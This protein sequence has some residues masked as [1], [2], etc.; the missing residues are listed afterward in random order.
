MVEVS[1]PLDIEPTDLVAAQTAGRP[2]VLVDCREQWEYEIVHLPNS[3]LIPLGELTSRA[4]EV[5]REGDVVVYCHHGVR[6]RRGA[7]ILRASGLPHARS[8]AGGIDDW[9][10]TIDPSLPRY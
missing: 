9:A 10:A 7:M 1:V 2:V 3:V 4:A 5:P 6:S 8:L